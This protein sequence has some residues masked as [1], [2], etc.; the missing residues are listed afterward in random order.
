MTLPALAALRLAAPHAHLEIGVGSWNEPLARALP[1]VD[2][3][4]V[5]DTPWASWGNKVRFSD[6]RRALGREPFDLA[7]DFQGDVRVLLL[8]AL[9]RAEMRAGYGET[10]GGYLLTHRARWNEAKSWYWQ[11][12]ELVRALFPA[13]EEIAAASPAPFN[14]VLPSDREAAGKLL[15]RSGL[16]ERGPLI[17]I[18]PSAGRALKQWE[19]AKFSEL[20]D[21][22]MKRASVVLTGAE[23]DRSLVDRIAH[24]AKS[25]PSKLLG[26]DLRTFAALVESFDV[27][28]TGDTGPMH[29]AHAVGTANVAI[30][31][32]SDP[33]R[34]GPEDPFDG[35]IVVRQPVYCSPCNMIRRPPRECTRVTAPE[36]IAGITVERVEEAVFYLLKR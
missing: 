13:A 29:V 12:M 35:R 15:A 18:H 28:V 23:G 1:F 32:P 7:I 4:R 10:G 20:V 8:M 17:G 36:C 19:A 30:F 21:R 33:V 34:Y 9:S 5:I 22:L 26:A 3:V 14:F 25:S 11:N 24:E 6:A 16:A 31:G 27:F 2:A